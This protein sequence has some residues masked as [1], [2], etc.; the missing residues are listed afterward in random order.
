MGGPRE[1]FETTDWT[2]IV[3]AQATDAEVRRPALEVLCRQYWK[4]VYCY[5]RRKGYDNETA[6][7]LTQGF[8]AEVVL[9]RKLVQEADAA[10]GRF[11]NFLLAGL[12]RYVKNVHRAEAAQKR[13]PEA[14]VLPLGDVDDAA[15]PDPSPDATPERAFHRQWAATLL[16]Q[17]LD[18]VERR[19]RDRGE[20]AHWDAFRARVVQ[21][22]LEDA[23]P[24]P[25]AAVCER[26]GIDSPS[27][28]SNMVV[29]VK[30]RFR[31]ALAR[32]VRPLVDSDADVDAEIDDLLEILSG[33]RAGY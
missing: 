20:A 10:K 7:D 2:A 11:R 33:S 19:C 9:G 22:I 17:A 15:L 16:E 3:R 26:H 30:R 1:R 18:D 27:T 24:V 29:T 21:P 8:F 14:P 31:A 5:L 23:L 12:E 28:A 32:R 25:L 6:K 13:R 4:P